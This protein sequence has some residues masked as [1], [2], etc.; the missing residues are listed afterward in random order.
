[1]K[2]QEIGT[3]A[4]RPTTLIAWNLQGIAFQS[5]LVTLAVALPAVAHL[6]GL[7]VRYLLPMHAPVI[8]AGL[9]Y[10]WRGGLATGLLSPLVSFLISG[11]PFPPMILPMTLELG[12]YGLIA[13][14][15]R[16]NARLNSFL[17]VATAALAGRIVFV[18]TVL[19][20]GSVNTPFVAYLQAAM[21]PGLIGMVGQIALLPFVAKW[22]VDRARK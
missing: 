7:P 10:G 19:L 9:V 5:L 11:M 17:S 22:W 8:L 15:L 21:L 6:T 18:M 1:M 12:T 14:L 3:I 16:E 20:A 2:E 13:G 4:L